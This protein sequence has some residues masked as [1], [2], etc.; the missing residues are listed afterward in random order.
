[1][2]TEDIIQ[3]HTT[4]NTL[5]LATDGGTAMGIGYFGWVLATVMET[6]IKAKGHATGTPSLMDSLRTE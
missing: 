1:M 4:D 3:L 2:D 5:Y 6:I